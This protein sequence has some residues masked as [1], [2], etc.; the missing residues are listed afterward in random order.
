MTNQNRKTLNGVNGT[1]NSSSMITLGVSVSQQQGTFDRNPVTA[2][3]LRMKTR[4][5][6]WNVRTMNQPGKLECITREAIRFKLDVFGLS[7]VRWKNSGRFTTD[8]HVMIYSGHQTEHKHGVGVLLS[9]QVAK[10]MMGFDA[11]SDRILLVKIVRKPFDLVIVQVYA[12]TSTSPEDEIEKLYDDLDSAYKM[13]GSQEM[14]IVMGDLNAKVVTEQDPLPE[15]VGRYGLGSRNERGDMWVDWC[16]THDQ[17]IMIHGSNI[18]K[19][20]YIHGR[21]PVMA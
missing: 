18:T 15:V 2:C 16:M 20:I 5:A 19:Y 14:K 7:E 13:C 9:K 12:P 3:N 6:T 17:V 11:L 8:E 10:L 4:I 1:A 21:V